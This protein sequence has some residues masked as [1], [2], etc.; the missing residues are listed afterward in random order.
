MSTSQ[1]TR[2][3][4]RQRWKKEI[5]QDEV[6]HKSWKMNNDQEPEERQGVSSFRI[7]DILA[8]SPT[9][10]SSRSGGSAVGLPTQT[11]PCNLSFGVERILAAQGIFGVTS[12]RQGKFLLCMS[13]V[14]LLQATLHTSFNA[15]LNSN[16]L[17]SKTL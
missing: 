3:T 16:G 15:S 13:L 14:C 17:E 1:S 4:N 12:A 7:A 8:S 2:T 11:S 9:H 6:P 10:S 5:E